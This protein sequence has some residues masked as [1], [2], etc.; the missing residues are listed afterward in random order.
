M[1]RYTEHLQKAGR[2]ITI[3]DHMV[4]TTYKVV[5]DP[6]V[7]VAALENT[8]LA[9]ANSLAAILHFEREKKRIPPFHNNFESKWNMFQLRIIEL[10]KEF[11]SEDIQFIEKIHK[12]VVFHKK[13]PVEFSKQ[14]EYVMCSQDY[15]IE[16]LD[17][18]NVGTFIQK[19]REFHKKVHEVIKKAQ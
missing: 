11:T 5:Q 14:S 18:T 15:D 12:L 3:S 8:F 2:Y 4:I 9:I 13:S 17:A 19:T 6:K 16:K 10:H 7:L 1:D